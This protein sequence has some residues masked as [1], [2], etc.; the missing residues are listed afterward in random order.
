MHAWYIS[1]HLYAQ[2]CPWPLVCMHCL[3]YTYFFFV[4]GTFSSSA[5][6]I[7]HYILGLG[8]EGAW[9]VVL[10]VFRLPQGQS[11]DYVY[12]TAQDLEQ[13]CIC[14]PDSGLEGSLCLDLE[15]WCIHSLHSGLGGSLCLDL[16]QCNNYVGSIL[17]I[18]PLEV[19]LY[20]TLTGQTQ[21]GL[22]SSQAPPPPSPQDSYITS[23]ECESCSVS[24]PE[25]Y[26]A[27][28]DR[29][30]SSLLPGYHN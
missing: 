26:S 14:S 16:E 23:I 19:E 29:G 4:Q 15:Q 24:G 1:D 10:S 27:F 5:I 30:H 12:I 13:W 18:W 8:G 6:L 17:H 11:L 21:T 2:V 25:K 3:F 28:R 9:E 22:P 7:F 20:K